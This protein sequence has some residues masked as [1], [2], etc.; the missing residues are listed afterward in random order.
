MSNRSLIEVWRERWNRNLIQ[1]LRRRVR[2]SVD[3]EDL[4]QETYMRLLRA[5]D[6]VE[7][8]NPQAYLLKVAGH[9]L[10]EWR[11]RQ[12]LEDPLSLVDENQLIDQCDL[13][14][15]LDATITQQRLDQVLTEIPTVTQ[16]V[17]LLKFR[18]GKTRKEV[19]E[20]LGMTDRQVRRHLVKG[21]EYLRGSFTEWEGVSLNENE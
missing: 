20:E 14:C 4:A 11:E 13:E 21:Y 10:H 12:M 9:V 6:L 17:M 16:A 15:D 2:I 19:A 18:D 8:Q 3:I 7:V 1:F 5:R